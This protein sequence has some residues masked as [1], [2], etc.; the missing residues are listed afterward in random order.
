[1]LAG[2]SVAVG[3][4]GIKIAYNWVLGNPRRD[5][6]VADFKSNLSKHILKITDEKCKKIRDAIDSVK[7]EMRS[8][9]RQQKHVLNSVKT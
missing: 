5:K 9:I 2:A 8:S 1:M 7:L 4:Y 3:A 6:V